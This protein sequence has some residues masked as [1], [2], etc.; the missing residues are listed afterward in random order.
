[1]AANAAARGAGASDEVDQAGGKSVPGAVR[2]QSRRRQRGSGCAPRERTGST[3]RALRGLDELDHPGLELA[4]ARLAESLRGEMRDPA[5]NASRPNFGLVWLGGL[6]LQL[7][8][9][10]ALFRAAE[11]GADI[12]GAPAPSLATRG[13][14]GMLNEAIRRSS[15]ASGGWGHLPADAQRVYFQQ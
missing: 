15:K 3:T 11:R 10:M 7:G 1:M 4:V 8:G 14:G 6:A 12:V 2:H 9:L 13:H 5:H